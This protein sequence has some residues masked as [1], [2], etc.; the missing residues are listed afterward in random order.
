MKPTWKRKVPGT[1]IPEGGRD[2]PGHGFDPKKIVQEATALLTKDGTVQGDNDS[3]GLSP[4]LVG[5]GFQW[6]KL[7]KQAPVTEKRKVPKLVIGPT[8]IQPSATTPRAVTETPGDPLHKDDAATG[9]EATNSADGAGRP[10]WMNSPGQGGVD[11]VYRSQKPGAAGNSD[12][13][14]SENINDKPEAVVPVNEDS[15]YIW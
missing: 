7:P 9:D 15:Y 3:P 2:V 14:F 12:E 4:G 13:L 6:H 1:D 10:R 11:P 8:S 5:A